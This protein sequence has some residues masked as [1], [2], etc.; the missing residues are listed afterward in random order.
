MEAMTAVAASYNARAPSRL[1]HS[2]EDETDEHPVICERSERVSETD[3]SSLLV[4]LFEGLPA[5]ANRN[6]VIT[7]GLDEGLIQLLRRELL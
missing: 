1:S 3:T 5:H 7:E 4:S 6:R 2:A